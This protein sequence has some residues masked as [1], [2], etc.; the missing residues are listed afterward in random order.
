M[1]KPVSMTDIYGVITRGTSKQ[2]NALMGE[3][4]RQRWNSSH[5][6]LRVDSSSVDTEVQESVQNTLRMGRV[7]NNILPKRKR[8]RHISS[9]MR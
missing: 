6:S 2:R 5:P 9:F 1:V 3:F 7:L 4:A 8:S